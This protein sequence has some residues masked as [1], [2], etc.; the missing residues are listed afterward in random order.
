MS[1]SIISLA[2]VLLT[3][4]ATILLVVVLDKGPVGVLIGNFSGTLAVYLVLLAYRRMQL[5]LEFDRDVFRR[6][7]AWGMPL[8]P[9]VVALNLIDF[10]DRF[11]LVRIS[12]PGRARP[13]RDRHADLGGPPLP[14]RGVPHGL[15][16]VRL[17]DPRG[18]GEADVRLRAHLRHVLLLVGSRR[19]R[20][21]LAVD[22]A[23]ADDAGLLWRR[24]GRPAARVRVRRLRDVRGRGDVDRARRTTRLELDDHRRRG[25]LQRRAQPDPDPAVRDDRRGDLDGRLVLRDVP[26]DHLEGAEGLPGDL[27][28]ASRGRSRS[29]PRSSSSSSAGSSVAC[30]RRSRSPPC[31]RSCSRSPA[32]TCRRSARESAPSAGASC[33]AA[34]SVRRQWTR[35]RWPSS[36]R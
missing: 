12:G 26:R 31:I 1:Y 27:P 36:Q 11:F 14:A 25:P 7:T 10:S 32:S 33:S 16:R 29:G 35:E 8:V 24:A 15:A 6:M 28:V 13:V 2:N 5:G 21:E 19:A 23:P 17:L 20:T 22:R 9:S 34:F 3:V 18:G 30:R 4:G